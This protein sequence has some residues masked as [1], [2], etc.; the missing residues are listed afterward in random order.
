MRCSS[1]AQ[2]SIFAPG[3]LRRS[4]RRRA[5]AFFEPG[6][7]LLGRSLRMPWPR[8]LD[9]IADRDQRVPTALI[10]HRFEPVK[11]GEP[12]RDLRPGP[13][14][15]V[16]RRRLQPL[17]Q[18]RERFWRQDRRLGAIVNALIAEPVGPT[19]VVA[20]DQDAHPACRER[21]HLRH[22][23]DIVATRQK[24]ERMKMALGDRLRRRLVAPLKLRC[25]QMRLDG[26][27]MI[28]PSS[29]NHDPSI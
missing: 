19:L 15:A 16:V 20:F 10:V 5:G 13:Q 2:I 24:P 22:L 26:R 28:V 21:Q 6:T 8:L 18:R 3:C 12:A 9:R 23:I 4:P 7:I 29:P 27:V 17:L 14:T 25:A 1:V 11:A